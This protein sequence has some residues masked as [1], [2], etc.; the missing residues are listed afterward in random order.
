MQRAP[1]CCCGRWPTQAAACRCWCRCW[2]RRWCCCRRRLC[3]RCRWQRPPQLAAAP[4]PEPPPHQ[5][6][7]LPL[8]SACLHQQRWGQAGLTTSFMCRALS[9]RSRCPRKSI[10]SPIPRRVG[11][12][13]PS[14]GASS[15]GVG[16]A[17][18]PDPTPSPTCAAQHAERLQQPLHPPVKRVV[19]G[20]AAHVDAG[21]RQRRHV[22]CMAARASTRVRR[23]GR[24]ALL[25]CTAAAA[26][27]GRR[28][29]EGHPAWS[30]RPGQSDPPSTAASTAANG[31]PGCGADRGACGS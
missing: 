27:S 31:S 12:C 16:G 30:L 14:G 8:A 4:Q 1:R 7:S 26:L 9:A 22:A 3:L 28:Q 11:V 25:C 21:R 17:G 29:Q 6:P 20:Q 23:S 10:S 18:R 13:T 24:T 2:C 15:H 5:G 19:V